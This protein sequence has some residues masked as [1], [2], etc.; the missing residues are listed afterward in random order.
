MRNSGLSPALKA[1]PSSAL[2]SLA[3]TASAGV[4]SVL[5]FAVLLAGTVSAQEPQNDD[6]GNHEGNG[7]DWGSA[8]DSDWQWG[9]YTEIA[10]GE[11]LQNDAVIGQDA[12][13]KELR[14]RIELQYPGLEWQFSLKADINIDEVVN[15]TDVDLRQ[16]ELSFS[17]TQN[18]DLKVG[19]QILTWGTGQYLF[20][21]DLFPKDWQSFFSGRDDEYLKAP[22][23]AL[24]AS[25]FGSVINLD[26]VWMPEFSGD[27]FINGERFSFF[28]SRSGVQVSP[29]P[30]F[31]AQQPDSSIDF[32]ELALRLFNTVD[33]LEYAFYGYHG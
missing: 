33:T 13:L 12:T 2:F 30:P 11:R 1:H 9:G 27:R 29:R 26:L 8:T 6:W 31:G 15:D 4:I 20:L 28:D 14:Q 5:F 22:T 25:Y 19:R 7:D 24:K 10:L 17:P 3:R 23:T 18:W 21:N 16:A 32:T